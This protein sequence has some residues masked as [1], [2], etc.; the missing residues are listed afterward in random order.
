MEGD[1]DMYKVAVV[2]PQVSVERIL[3]I[4]DDFSTHLSFVPLIYKTATETSTIMTSYYNQFDFF[5]LSGPIP[6]ELAKKAVADPSKLFAIDLLETGFYKALLNLTNHVQKII[7][8]LSID[9]LNT[10]NV[11]D[12]SLDQLKITTEKIYVKTF[13]AEI[14][15]LELYEHHLELWN[16]GKIEGVLTCYPEVM[17]L[18]KEQGV[19]AEW[20]STTK[21]ETKQVVSRIEQEAQVS[22]VLRTQI[23]VCIIDVDTKVYKEQ[24]D[25]L[26][27]DI[28]LENLKMNEELLLLS[29]EMNGSF[30]S[31]SDG[32][33]MIFSSRGE[34]VDNIQI[35]NA[36][37]RNLKFSWN[38]IIT[39]G[40]G[41]GDSALKAELHAR[42]AIHMSQME[43]EEIVLIDHF[44]N[45]L[46]VP[47]EHGIILDNELLEKLNAQNISVQV[48]NQL[49]DII[50]R[51]K[52]S[53]FNSKDI[54]LEFKMGNRN[55]QRLL[56][57]L[58][59]SK[60]IRQVGEEKSVLRGRP[61]KLYEM[62]QEFL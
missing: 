56:R 11:V 35:I 23:G 43:N 46:D 42:K 60:V 27:Y 32:K 33:Y 61:S 22:F 15:Y 5:L 20:I 9:I 14:D 21:L 50:R 12:V 57:S 52:W 6:Y 54:A 13:E 62:K 2:G 18:L 8:K 51:K 49:R 38:R 25:Q 59:E 16:T 44:G 26:S 3:S 48:F 4:T 1:M 55:A 47:T 53:Q 7:R 24:S 34:I 41:F 17:E 40:I 37:I 28:Q 39:A 31:I 19:P 29:R 30:F 10:S 36:A 45:L 58:T